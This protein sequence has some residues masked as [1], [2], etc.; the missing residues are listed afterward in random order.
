MLKGL[1]GHYT[2][3]TKDLGPHPLASLIASCCAMVRQIGVCAVSHI[4]RERNAVADCLAKWS[5]NIDLG[6]CVLDAAPSWIGALLVDDLLGV[7][8]TRWQI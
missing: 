4:Y 5:H 6:L 7:H 8:R 1:I 2:H 3:L